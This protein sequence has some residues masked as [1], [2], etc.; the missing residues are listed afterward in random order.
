MKSPAGTELVVALDRFD[1]DYI[2]GGGWAL[3]G[4]NLQLPGVA[5]R[6]GVQPG[7]VTALPFE[8]ESFDA[9]ASAHAV[10]HLGRAKEAGLREI[11]RVLKPGGRAGFEIVDDGSFNGHCFLL[12]ARLAQAVPFEHSNDGDGGCFGFRENHQPPRKHI[13]Y[14]IRDFI[15]YHDPFAAR[16][17]DNTALAT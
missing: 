5:N 15:A 8:D 9:A 2:A 10:D 13:F 7:D 3:H 16:C 12:L 4:R 1:A 6:V 14:A 17:S 11:W